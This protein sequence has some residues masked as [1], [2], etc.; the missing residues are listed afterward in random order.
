LKPP[1]RCSAPKRQIGLGGWP[2]VAPNKLSASQWG[3]CEGGRGTG[4]RFAEELETSP[5]AEDLK[6]LESK[7]ARRNRGFGEKN[8][9]G[10]G[11]KLADLPPIIPDACFS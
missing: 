7:E 2:P 6:N 3:G 1:P 10:S 4:E 11:K 9:G 5:F 8:G